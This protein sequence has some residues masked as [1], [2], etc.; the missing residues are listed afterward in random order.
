MITNKQLMATI[1]S[2]NGTMTSYPNHLPDWKES[3]SCIFLSSPKENLNANLHPLTHVLSQT[4][5]PEGV[6]SSI[7]FPDYG[8]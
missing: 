5:I 7:T 8:V 1:K 3:S 6:S 4:L 2:S